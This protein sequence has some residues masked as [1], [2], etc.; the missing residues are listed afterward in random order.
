MK[1]YYPMKN[2]VTSVK[3]WL[4]AD[5]VAVLINHAMYRNGPRPLSVEHEAQFVLDWAC[6]E[7]AFGAE[8]AGLLRAAGSEA[9]AYDL[10]KLPDPQDER[11][12]RQREKKKRKARKLLGV[13]S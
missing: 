11:V 1:K 4:T 6:S 7:S 2:R 12:L 13:P 8:A 10:A 5:Q 3:L 9:L